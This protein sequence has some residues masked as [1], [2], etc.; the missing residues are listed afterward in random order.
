MVKNHCLSQAIIDASWSTFVSMLAYK[1]DW[2]GRNI[3][4]IGQFAPSS[5]TC[6]NCGT[7]NKELSLKDRAWTC[8]SCS[9]VL[10]RDVNA[11]CNIK[12]FALRKILSV[13]PTLKNQNEL[14]ALVG[15]MTSEAQPISYAVG[16]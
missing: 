8:S 4:R 2:Y 10:D 3:V 6:C 13:E 7:I 16:G 9:I 5:K 1:S 12:S 15:V 11:A 14:P